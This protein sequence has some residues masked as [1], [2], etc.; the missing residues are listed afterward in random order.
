MAIAREYGGIRA[1]DASS[2]TESGTE[3]V[4]SARLTGLQ[5]TLE[6]YGHAFYRR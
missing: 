2:S 3:S 6:A 4:Q 5:M 1:D